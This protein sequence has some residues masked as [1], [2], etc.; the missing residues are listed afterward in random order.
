MLGFDIGSY[1]LKIANW[2]GKSISQMACAVLP[3]NYVKED[4]VVNFDAMA[5]FIKETMNENG[6]KGKEA[7]IILPASQLYVRKT[8]LPYMDKEKLL[9]N[10]PYEFRDY[11]TAD[12]ASYYYDYTLN[13]T[14]KNSEGEPVE[15]EITA[16]AV[17]KETIENYRAMFKRAG[18]RLSYAAPAE[19]AYENLLRLDPDHESKEYG[20]LDVGHGGT[21]LQIY[22]GAQFQATRALNQGLRDVDEA[23]ARHLNVDLRLAHMYKEDGSKGVLVADYTLDIFNSIANDARKAINFYGLNNRESHLE[24]IYLAGGGDEFLSFR[25]TLSQQLTEDMSVHSVTDL[26]PSDPADAEQPGIYAGAIGAAIGSDMNLAQKEKSETRLSVTLPLILLIVLLAA[27]FSKYGVMDRFQRL[28]ETKQKLAMMQSE[29]KLLEAQ[30]ADYDEVAEEYSRYATGFLNES[31]NALVDKSEVFKLIDKELIPSGRITEISSNAQAVTCSIAGISLDDASRLVEKL[32][33]RDDVD[34][35]YI[36]SVT[37]QE[38]PKYESAEAEAAANAEAIAAGAT[39]PEETV[40]MET[41][42]SITV[43]MIKLAEGENENA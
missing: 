37:T 24:N 43:S 16:A 4:Y 3:D 32:Y 26:Y 30:L 35:V 25:N 13:S 20:I 40:E 12:K 6:I 1:S 33:A 22:K 19:L 36:S 39:E 38:A 8:T 14:V 27:A 10:L 29:T 42:V 21:R 11:L 17:L 5:D 18:L 41:V 23:I 28:E 7:A 2:N 9:I 15:M 34:S 31:E